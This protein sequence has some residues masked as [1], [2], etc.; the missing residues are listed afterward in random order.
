MK[1]FL[2][3]IQKGRIENL[4]IEAF[5]FEYFKFA[6]FRPAAFCFGLTLCYTLYPFLRFF[7]ESIF[8]SWSKSIFESLKD[9]KLSLSMLKFSALPF[10]IVIAVIRIYLDFYHSII[11]PKDWEKGVQ[12]LVLFQPSHQIWLLVHI[13]HLPCYIS[14]VSKV[15][16]VETD[17][18]W[19]SIF[20][21]ISNRKVILCYVHCTYNLYFYTY[22]YLT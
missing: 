21:N 3:T 5:F 15:F 9:R 19:M 11:F 10:S 12:I 1:V 20:F 2:H 7:Y 22:N 18:F 14:K 4:N 6:A 17:R 8:F 16:D 13:F